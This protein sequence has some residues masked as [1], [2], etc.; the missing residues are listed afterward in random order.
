MAQIRARLAAYLFPRYLPFFD[1]LNRNALVGAWIRSNRDKVQIFD[2]K[3]DLYAYVNEHVC[4]GGPIDYLEFGVYKGETIRMWTEINKHADSRFIGFDSFTGLPDD[5]TKRHGAGAFD[6]QGAMPSIEDKR[7]SFVKG[8]FQETLRPT[9]QSFSPR[10]RLV[11]HN[12]S[13]LYSSTLYVLATLDPLIVARSVIIF[14]EFCV[15]LHEFRGFADY[16]SAFN[17]TATPV[18]ITKDFATQAAF[19]FS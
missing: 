7:V 5:W 14:D 15:A 19:V 4:A 1:K 13:D 10:S 11:I 2:H 12:D 3:R 18:A 16:M 17:R 8:W 9:L 6:L